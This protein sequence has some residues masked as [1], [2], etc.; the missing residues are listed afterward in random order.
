ML[1]GMIECDERDKKWS[2]MR[3]LRRG[4]EW[5][6]NS[7]QLGSRES[8]GRSVYFSEKT[9]VKVK[10]PKDL[11]QKPHAKGLENLTQRP[12]STDPLST[13]ALCQVSRRVDGDGMADGQ[14]VAKE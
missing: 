3:S 5:M 7:I 12:G 2:N 14:N 10:Q 4:K 6:G 1:N 9:Q 8:S 11:P 13:P